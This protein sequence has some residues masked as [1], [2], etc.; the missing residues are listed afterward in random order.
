MLL[1]AL[2]TLLDEQT[3][4]AKRETIANCFTSNIRNPTYHAF[5]FQNQQTHWFSISDMLALVSTT[6]LT[7]PHCS[8]RLA[9]LH[10]SH[11]CKDLTDLV[12]LVRLLGD[13][14]CRRGALTQNYLVPIPEGIHSFSYKLPEEAT[15]CWSSSFSR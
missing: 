14:I 2:A 4:I 6:P 10:V 5:E 7:L 1:N 11:P 15:S 8:C 9:P 13:D 3:F 12:Q